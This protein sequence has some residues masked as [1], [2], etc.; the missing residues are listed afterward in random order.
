MLGHVI[1]EWDNMSDQARSETIESLH[2]FGFV[3]GWVKDLDP[4]FTEATHAEN[5]GMYDFVLAT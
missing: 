3:E 5:F 1:E 4:T 2:G